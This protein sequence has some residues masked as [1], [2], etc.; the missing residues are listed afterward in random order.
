MRIKTRTPIYLMVILIVLAIPLT[1]LAAGSSFPE[2]I[3]LPTGFFPEGIAV[4]KGHTFYTG[5]LIDGAIFRGDL[6]TGEGEILV[7]G[8][9]GRVSVGMSFDERSGSLFV[10]GGPSGEAFVFDGYTGAEKA[11]YSLG[12]GFINDVI[13]TRQAAYFTNSFA[14]EYYV[15]PLGPRGALPDQ[16]QVVTIPLSGDWVQ[17][18]GF[19][20]NG[21]E[22]TSD[23]KALIVVN[24]GLGVLHR[25]DP[26][27]G[28]ASLIDLG[29]ASV[30][31][32]DGLLLRGSSLFVVRN[33]LNQID[34]F[35]LDSNLESGEYVRT[36]T[37]PH[38]DI[39]TTA[40]AFGNALY[41]VNARFGIPNPGSADYDAVRV[42]IN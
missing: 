35:N 7:P 27:S 14:A 38:F 2:V 28:V 10:A 4:G 23:G 40:A 3:P 37:N 8:V 24:S 19:N 11:V 15:L 17:A 21:I 36:L 18:A 12:A 33:Q 16:D 31:S 5:S 41:A 26:T 42:P 1:A 34:E 30:A 25:V 22:A 9:P 20:A 39:P 6:R 13:V 29:G 32:G